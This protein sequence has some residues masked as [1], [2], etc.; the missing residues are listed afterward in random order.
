MESSLVLKPHRVNL[1]A[2]DEPLM[3]SNTVYPLMLKLL[4]SPMRILE[5]LVSFVSYINLIGIHSF[6][7][8]ENWYENS[9]PSLNSFGLLQPRVCNNT[10]NDTSL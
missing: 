9:T 10:S 7:R 1:T 5:L 6:G 4:K 3:T 2:L 8:E